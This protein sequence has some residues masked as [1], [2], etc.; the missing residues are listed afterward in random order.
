MEIGD[1]RGGFE[2]ALK[3][4]DGTSLLICMCVLVV[5]FECVCVDSVVRYFNAIDILLSLNQTGPTFFSLLFHLSQKHDKNRPQPPS[6][7]TLSFSSHR[8]LLT[9]DQPTHSIHADVSLRLQPCAPKR[10]KNL[11]HFRFHLIHWP[12]S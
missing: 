11:L 2:M 3:D 9:A 12:T 6:Y 7:P 10:K 1:G 8:Q 5:D 4:A